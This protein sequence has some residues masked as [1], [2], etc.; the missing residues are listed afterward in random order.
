MASLENRRRVLWFRY[1]APGA[2]TGKEAER[3]CLQFQLAALDELGAGC[4]MKRYVASLLE[5]PT[6][7]LKWVRSW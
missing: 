5:N 1:T 3:I 2:W 4:D 6:Y 7:H